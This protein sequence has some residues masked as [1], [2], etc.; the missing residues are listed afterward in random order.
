MEDKPDTIKVELPKDQFYTLV[1][2]LQLIVVAGLEVNGIGNAI[3][4]KEQLSKVW[5]TLVS[6]G[7]DQRVM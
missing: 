2:F 5:K 3:P 4:T 1:N 7:L 6:I